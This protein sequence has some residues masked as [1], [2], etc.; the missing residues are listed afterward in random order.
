[1]QIYA[2]RP[3]IYSANESLNAISSDRVLLFTFSPIARKLYF[4]PNPL[5]G[6]EENLSETSHC[7]KTMSYMYHSLRLLCSCTLSLLVG[8]W[9]ETIV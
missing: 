2:A 8:H 4:N 5:Q 7:V 1:M 9:G 3:V 6:T